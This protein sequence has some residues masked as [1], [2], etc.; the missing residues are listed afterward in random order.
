MKD[1]YTKL[2]NIIEK[3]IN[4]RLNEIIEKVDLNEKLINKIK[5]TN[6]I[7]A[8]ENKTI[9][10]KKIKNNVEKKDKKL[11]MYTTFVKDSNNIIKDNHNLSYLPND[12]VIE[13]NK[14]KN[15]S[16]K[17][18]FK[19]LGIIWKTLDNKFVNK[20]KD[21]T[22][23]KDFTNEKY[24]ETVGKIQTPKIPR[25]KKSKESLKA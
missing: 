18:K 3:L 11:S 12:V 21:L 1:N 19:E 25:K 4:L 7:I 6:N 24:N 13:L 14:I 9:K 2:S 16:A 5:D 15:K 17:E 23:N 10:K 22:K 20:Y 8:N